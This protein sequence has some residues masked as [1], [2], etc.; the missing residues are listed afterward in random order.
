M[1]LAELIIKFILK[2][3]IKKGGQL[4]TEILIAIGIFA[5]ISATIIFLVIDAYLTNRT[6]K[7]KT[8]AVFL[9]KEGIEA[10]RSIR[11]NSWQDLLS[12]QH[13][14]AISENHWIFQGTEDDLSQYF[15][16]GKR[17]IIIEDIGPDEKKITS[18]VNWKIS[19][20]RTQEVVLVTYLTNWQKSS[21]PFIS[22]LHYRW[23]NDDGG[24]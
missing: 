24:E 18:R 7:E 2:V 19:E 8:I 23:R 10:V 11:E 20:N 21:N 3:K 1:R 15:K 5:L 4:L 6:A 12:G 14:L 16:E 22:Q 13:G 9:A 17:R